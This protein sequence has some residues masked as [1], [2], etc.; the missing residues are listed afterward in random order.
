MKFIV[1]QQS[2]NR[3]LIAPTIKALDIVVDLWFSSIRRLLSSFRIWSK[4]VHVK[5]WKA[6]SKGHYCLNNQQFMCIELAIIMRDLSGF[7]C[8]EKTFWKSHQTFVA[9][10]MSKSATIAAKKHFDCLFPLIAQ[11][12]FVFFAIIFESQPQTIIFH[13]HHEKL[14]KYKK[15]ICLS[16]H[17]W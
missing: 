17:W 13:F 2:F 15:S 7:N 14:A 5:Q 6:C 1:K 3:S 9:N 12:V 11:K 10:Q 16:S 8:S 4:Q